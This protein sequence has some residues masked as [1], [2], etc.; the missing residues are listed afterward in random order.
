MFK[1]INIL[2]ACLLTT[3]VATSAAIADGRLEGRV[4]AADDTTFLEGARVSIPALN[5]TVSTARDG[6]FTFGR[7][8]A[9]SHEVTVE[10]LGAA[11][12]TETVSVRDGATAQLSFVIGAE[13]DEIVVR[14]QRAGT[15]RALN[16]QR[17]SDNVVSVI[18][19]EDIGA[20]PDANVAEAVQRVPGVF[21][22]RD[23][24]EGRYI[25]V[26]GVDPNLNI[27]TINGLY[28]P[29]PDAG[30]RSVALD[31]IPSDLL[32]G[33][34]V[35]KT[36]TPDMEASAIGGTVNVR[37]LSAFDRDGGTFSVAAEGSY[38][39]L[40]EEFSPKLSGSYTNTFGADDN[41]GLAFAASWFDR[42][43]GSDNIETDGGWFDG[44]E[45][46]D[47]QVFKGAEEI[48]QRSYTVNRERIGLALNLDARTD[49]GRYYWRNLYSEFSDQEYRM[50]NEFKF[51]DGDAIS[52]SSS[53]AQW[54]G[55]TIEKSM[56]DRLEEQT[57]LSMLLGGENYFNQWTIDYSYGYSYGEETEPARLDTEFELEDI[58][59]GY[60]S[61]GEI[62]FL[63]SEAGAA[64]ADNYVIKE[65]VYL[66]GLAEDEANTFKANFT[67]D[68]FSD[69]YNGNI[70]FGALYRTRDKDYNAEETIYELSLI[71]I[72]EPTRQLA[73]S[74]MPSSA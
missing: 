74:R 14:G 42:D 27:T 18:A 38:N 17:M 48:E 62:P 23:Q 36:F 37:S 49:N 41:F 50:R 32:E 10:Y 43:F 5:R 16:Q 8:P 57:I 60:S 2:R 12:Q 58:T 53:S 3:L 7:V 25:G 11:A 73:S 29:S 63:T 52:G 51:D 22:D 64:V 56:K 68:L 70:K 46:V 4:I 20:L 47:E 21:L 45:T 13:L 55:A 31:V 71:H 28:V 33:L 44:L 34:E 40:V 69:A 24:G 1:T 19:A 15:T 39:G 66:D 61:I 9:G 30:A 72:S 35:Y 54:E 59:I 65:F 67:Y 26:R 6:R